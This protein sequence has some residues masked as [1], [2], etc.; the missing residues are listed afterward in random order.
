MGCAH[1]CLYCYTR[2]YR[3]YPGEGKLDVYENTLHKLQ[4]ELRRKRH[5]PDAVYFSPASDLFQPVPDVLD[6][7]YEVIRYLLANGIGIAF[8]SEAPRA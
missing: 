4:D 1:G 3:A 7:A 5:K 8:L 2:G 6:M